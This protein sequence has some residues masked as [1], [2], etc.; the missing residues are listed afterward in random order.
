M[1]IRAVFLH[2]LRLIYTLDFIMGTIFISVVHTMLQILV[3][4]GFGFF[5][6]KRN[7]LP[8]KF[9]AYISTF[10]IKGTLPIYMFSKVIET[11]RDALAG[12]WLF[13]ISAVLIIAVGVLLAFVVFTLL[14]FKGKEKRAGL[15]MSTFGNS[16]YI[17]LTLIEIFPLTMPLVIE[18]YGTAVPAL[19]VGTYVLVFSPL[20]WTFGHYLITGKS[21]FSVRNIITPPFIGLML[22]FAAIL[23]HI[24]TPIMN[25]D[26]FLHHIYLG[27]RRFGSTTFPLILVVLGAMIANINLNVEGKWRLSQMAIGVFT[28]R[29]VL[30]PAF[31]YALYFTVLRHL[32]FIT[33][34]HIWILFLETHLPPASNLSIMV[35]EAGVNQGFTAFSLLITYLGFLIIFPVHMVLFLQLVG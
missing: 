25:E 8:Q 18:R 14:P 29:F 10:L 19:Y 2:F 6:R 30:L 3:I 5:L 13:P 31:F 35:S 23:L 4:M 12:T 24:N 21:Y 9:F 28:V 20:L 26:L 17:P 16:A 7:I 11:D 27:L 15:A 34:V 1:S 33:P 32:D 22:G